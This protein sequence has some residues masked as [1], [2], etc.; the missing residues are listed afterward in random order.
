[1]LW[2]QDAHL[3]LEQ[4]APLVVAHDWADAERRTPLS[5]TEALDAFLEPPLDRV[6]IDLDIKLPGR[7]EEI[8]AALR[9]R[10]LVER[11]MVS[12]MELYSLG[13]M[14]ELEPK[15]RRG[16]TYPKVTKDWTSKRWAKAPMLAALVGMRY[17]LPGLAAEKFT[18]I[19]VQAMWVYHPLISAR[20]ARICRLAG[21]ELIAWTV[22]DEP[23]MRALVD[24]GVTG[25][26][27][28]DPR[29]FARLAPHPQKG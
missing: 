15:L 24:A 4:R 6:E 18:K 11:A 26:C 27:S 7:E 20:L 1:V 8:V 12:T 23:R 10:D 5:L 2:L 13:R 22:D 19:D 25:L 3:P 21:V 17:R 29:L 16:W 14:L 28:N 9:E